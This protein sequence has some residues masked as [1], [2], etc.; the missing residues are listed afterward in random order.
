MGTMINNSVQVREPYAT[1]V[2]KGESSKTQNQTTLAETGPK[3]QP[4]KIQE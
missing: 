2:G 3:A 4:M 1:T